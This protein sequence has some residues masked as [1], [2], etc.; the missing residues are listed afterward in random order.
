MTA[1]EKFKT[2]CRK[3]E[4]VQFNKSIV[5]KEALDDPELKK[6]IQEYLDPNKRT[7]LKPKALKGIGPATVN[8]LR[9]GTVENLR[10]MTPT[11]LSSEDLPEFLLDNVGNLD[12][13]VIQV[14]GKGKR[15]LVDIKQD[16]IMLRCSDTIC[17]PVTNCELERNLRNL[18]PA[19][20]IIL[21]GL[22]FCDDVK[23]SELYK[24]LFIPGFSP[25]FPPA[26]KSSDGKVYFGEKGQWHSILYD[27]LLDSDKANLNSS[28][29][30]E[31]FLDEDERFISRK[32]AN[33]KGW[34]RQTKVLSK[35]KLNVIDYVD[36]NKKFLDRERFLLNKN[37]Q[38]SVS[39]IRSE[40]VTDIQTQIIAFKNSGYSNCIL[41][42]GESLYE[43]KRSLNMIILNF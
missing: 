32:E 23:D 5:L 31:G 20:D 2:F 8:F 14:T 38:N 4:S 34:F 25:Y 36:V 40:P 7:R 9:P 17:L 12:K 6:I 10:I 43:F 33:R 1:E 42:N 3:L 19:E 39:F 18:F 21:D 37:F 28:D 13:W 27:N 41:R 22:I 26:L 29:F 16:L 15:C 24:E 30:E 35:L 11:N